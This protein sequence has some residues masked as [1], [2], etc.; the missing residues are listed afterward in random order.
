MKIIIL[1]AGKVGSFVTQDLS[2]EGHDIVV[3]DRD[4]EVLD[5]LLATNDVMGLVGDGRDVEALIEAG[6]EYCCLLYT[7]DAADE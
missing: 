2:N 7:S 1:G 5:E 6:A 4:K 3:I